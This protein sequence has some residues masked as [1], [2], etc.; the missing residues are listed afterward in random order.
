MKQTWDNMG[1]QVHELTDVL[2]DIIDSVPHSPEM[3]KRVR[4]LKTAWEKFKRLYNQFDGFITPVNSVNVKEPWN[5]PEFLESWQYW[6]DYLIE[7]HGVFMRSRSEVMALKHLKEITENNPKTAIRYL[8]FAM[9]GRYANFF[10]V[11]ETEVESEKSNENGQQAKPT[12]FK[13]KR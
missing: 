10:K 2:Q 12:V 9:A 5:D 7:Q 1:E 4:R 13:I 8:E 6:K 11:K 3:M